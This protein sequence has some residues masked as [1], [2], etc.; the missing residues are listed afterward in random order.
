[1]IIASIGKSVLVMEDK[2]VV[3]FD[4]S[5]LFRVNRVLG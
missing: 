5:I 2:R 3:R 1:M 4:K